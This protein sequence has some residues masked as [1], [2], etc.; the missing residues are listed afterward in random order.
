MQRVIFI[1]RFK[2]EDDGADSI[3][4]RSTLAGS[5]AGA[6]KHGGGRGRTKSKRTDASKSI[7]AYIKNL[8]DLYE[9]TNTREVHPDAISDRVPWH[10]VHPES[11]FRIV[12]DVMTLLLVIFFAVIVPYRVGF[13]VTLSPA[14][15]AFDYVADIIFLVDILISF[16]TAFKEDGC[17]VYST[18]RMAEHYIRTW[19]FLDLLASVPIGWFVQETGGARSVNRLFRLLRLFKLFR[20]L[21][22]LKLF[23]RVMALIETSVKLNPAVLRFLRSF[24]GLITVWH[25]IG[26]LYYFT[27]RE[28]YGGVVACKPAASAQPGEPVGSGFC[29]VNHCICASDDGAAGS[30]QIIEGTLPGWYN[31]YDPDLWVPHYSMANADDLTKY[32]QAVFWAVEVTTGIGDDI[33][34]HSNLEVLFTIVVAVIGLIVYAVIIGSA[35]SAL[36]EIDAA[37]ADRR[38]TVERAMAYMRA[39]QVPV[40]FQ[41]IISDYFRHKWGTPED[42][43]DVL[44]SLPPSLQARLA[45][46]TNRDLID[47]IPLF[48]RIPAKHYISI[49]RRLS[50]NT[51]L[52]GEFIVRSGEVRRDLF[53]L[54]RG[55]V[56]A[57]MSNARTVYL[58]LNPGEIFNESA[59]LFGTA[60]EA[61]YRAVDFVDAYSMSSE[62]FDEL[63]AVAPQFL[64]EVRQIDS[65][66]QT[67]RLRVEVEG[68]RAGRKSSL[69]AMDRSACRRAL[70]CGKPPE[71]PPSSVPPGES[72]S[73]PASSPRSAA[74]RLTS[75][76]CCG[77][78]ESP[79]D[80]PDGDDDTRVR[81]TDT[82]ILDSGRIFEPTAAAVALSSVVTKTAVPAA[83]RTREEGIV[84]TLRVDVA[85]RTAHIYDDDRKGV[86]LDDDDPTKRAWSSPPVSRASTAVEDFDEE[87]D[88]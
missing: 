71:A 27:A 23:P 43:A 28:E 47:R 81:P 21:R 32:L 25:Y 60:C 7:D 16:R 1:N 2:D 42:P 3:G 5:S 14:E 79:S 56:D 31:P 85:P 10:V 13:D 6:N 33:K 76:R 29:F 84:E 46:V 73:S 77:G 51:F 24:F 70:G 18:R 50:Q 87:A 19:F 66:R 52:P 72:R 36:L 62:L 9:Y 59:V 40:F 15:V 65:S 54:D 38:D 58:T 83:K 8:V 11:L 88:F 63:K 61:P 82:S 26:C 78:R 49:V 69:L 86:F 12:W 80:D 53:F 41:K 34:P 67:A 57:L 45:I 44:S 64:A 55:L 4:T 68:L 30:Y 39:R 20:I 74:T 35:S 75:C 37:A 17:T 48:Q 22:L